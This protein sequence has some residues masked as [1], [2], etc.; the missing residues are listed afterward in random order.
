MTEGH[1]LTRARNLRGILRWLAA[2]LVVLSVALA[3]V[4]VT[5]PH[6]T[7]PVVIVSVAGALVI[8][9]LALTLRIAFRNLPELE[10]LAAESDD[11]A[12]KGAPVQTAGDD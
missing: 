1:Y 10:K 7:T 9:L 12:D 4:V 8:V 11:E 5:R 6:L 2:L 3:T